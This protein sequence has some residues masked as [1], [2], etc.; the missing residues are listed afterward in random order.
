MKSFLKT[1]F[2]SYGSSL[3]ALVASISTWAYTDS[4]ATAQAAVVGIVVAATMLLFKLF[5]R[6]VS[7]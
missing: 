3:G 7:E 4:P 6:N 1:V 5:G 2:D